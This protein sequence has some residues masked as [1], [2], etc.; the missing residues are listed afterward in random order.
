[1]KIP[2]YAVA[3]ALA[4]FLLANPNETRIVQSY[5]P[6]TG[7]K[8]SEHLEDLL[9]PFAKVDIH[10]PHGEGALYLIGQ[11]HPPANLE[12]TGPRFLPDPRVP[13]VQAQIYHILLRLKPNVILGEG[14]KEGEFHY[15]IEERALSQEEYYSLQKKFDSDIFTLVEFFTHNY[16]ETAYTM[17]E[18]M[19]PTTRSFGVTQRDFQKWLAVAKEKKRLKEQGV[20]LTEIQ[21]KIRTDE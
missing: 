2:G 3:A 8:E 10:R 5:I 19:H 11:R 15:P 17:Y 18:A 7:T 13:I 12:E 9:R 14:F 6:S 20:D 1:M 16:K 21:K 4:G